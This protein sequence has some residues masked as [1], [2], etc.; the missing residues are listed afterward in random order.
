MSGNRRDLAPVPTPTKAM[1]SGV[2]LMKG[3]RPGRPVEPKEPISREAQRFAAAIL[4]VLAGMRTPTDAAAALGISVPRYYL[5]EQRALA[6]LVAGCEPRP[7]GKAVSQR[8]QL[9]VLQQEITWLKQD[10]ARQQALVRAAQRTIGLGPPPPT[11]SAPKAGGK[12]GG[13][14]AGKAAGKKARQRRPVVR[15]LKAVATLRAAAPMEETPADSSSAV[16]PEVL[17]RSVV[18]NLS[19]PAVPAQAAAA[20][21]GE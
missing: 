8:H 19:T 3:R 9:A 12:A 17:Q 6:G 1:P 14:A 5:W 2:V 10:C 13:K 16:S 15:A 11:K 4:E 21:A 20:V 7:V 18:T